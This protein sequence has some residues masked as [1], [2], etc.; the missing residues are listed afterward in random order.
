MKVLQ[1]NKLYYPSLGGIEVIVQDIAEGLKSLTK[2][3]VLACQEKGKTEISII[4][5]VCVYKAGS[6]GK[7]YSLPISLSF[8]YFFK[9]LLK[10]QDVLHIHLPFPLVN[11]ALFTN[12]FR[13]RIIISWHSDIVRQKVGAFF[14]RP[15][16][17]NTLKRADLIV[18]AAKGTIDGSPY[19]SEYRDKCIIIPY[20]VKLDKF[21]LYHNT[22]FPVKNCV[23]KFIFIGRLVYY[24]GC[25]VLLRALARTENASLVIIGDGYLAAR[26]KE[27]TSELNIV[28][29]VQYLGSVS[30]EEK[31]RQLQMCDVFILP[32]IEKSEA[33]GIVQIEAMAYGKPVINTNLMSGVPDVS[34]HNETG[35]TVEP[36]DIDALA[37]AIKWFVQHPNERKTMG[38]NA[39]KRVE[40]YFTYEREMDGILKVYKL[41]P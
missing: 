21:Q 35:L 17:N 4:N 31:H 6:F 23:L 28:D 8:F 12:K 26:L 1:V 9:K 27:V 3:T 14:L 37:K 34:I 33:F 7:F 29:R 39:R 10:N 15:L 30:E 22:N 19:L 5:D 32:S 16:I 25:E 38:L 13:G 24:K 36:N 41:N 18:V 11:I 2:M 40:E 20:G